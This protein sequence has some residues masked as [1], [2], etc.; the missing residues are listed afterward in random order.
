M[1][2]F[3]VMAVIGPRQ[4]G[5]STLVQAIY[6]DWKYYDLERPDDYQLI[7][8]DPWDF[9]AGNGKGPSLMRPSNSLNC[10]RFYAALLIKTG[11]RVEDICSPAQVRPILSGGYLKVWRE[12]LRPSS[13]GHLRRL[14]FMII[15][16]R[17]FIL[18][19]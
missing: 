17:Q 6:P 3:P 12:E 15:P 5:K 2:M 14:S 4:C 19:L 7:A 16:C 13:Y 18:Y 11:R 9:S 10:F 8:G 1:E